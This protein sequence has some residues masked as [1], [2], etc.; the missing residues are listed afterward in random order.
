MTETGKP[1]RGASGGMQG[2]PRRG[3]SPIT[4]PALPHA[5]QAAQ[6]TNKKWPPC[7][8]GTQSASQRTS[9]VSLP[10][11]HRYATSNT[12]RA[13]P[14]RLKDQTQSADP[15]YNEASRNNRP[16][17]LRLHTAPPRRFPPSHPARRRTLALRGAQG[18]RRAQ[19]GSSRSRSRAALVEWW[20]ME[21]PKGLTRGNGDIRQ[22]QRGRPGGVQRGPRRGGSP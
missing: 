5:A 12:S 4:G 22:A 1:Q 6:T 13:L 15:S 10:L 3:R 17:F 16:P 2:G 19:R 7:P 9:P 11:P 8:Q 18:D 21:S 14:T 20:N